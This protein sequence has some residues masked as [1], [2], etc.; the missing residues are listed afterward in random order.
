MTSYIFCR[1][2]NLGIYKF[3]Q[4]YSDGIRFGFELICLKISHF[5]DLLLKFLPLSFHIS[6]DLPF[7]SR[8]SVL[9]SFTSLII[10]SQYF[11]TQICLHIVQNGFLPAQII[12]IFREN[13]NGNQKLVD[14]IANS[15]ANRH[16]NIIP[17]FSIDSF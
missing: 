10:L 13:L 11:L 15:F 16:R 8:D 6:A 9:G 5:L 2:F 14:D 12:F 1:S 3:C 4:F 7:R 17:I